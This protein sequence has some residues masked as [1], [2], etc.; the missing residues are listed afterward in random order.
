VLDGGIGGIIAVPISLRR[1][2]FVGMMCLFDVRALTIAGD[3]LERLIHLGQLQSDPP[4]R[5]PSVASV[6]RSATPFDRGDKAP[7]S[8]APV[9]GSPVVRPAARDGGATI[10]CDVVP[11]HRAQR[12]SSLVRFHLDARHSDDDASAALNA[13]K[14]VIRGSDVM[15]QWDPQQ[16]L[17]VLPDAGVVE[18]QKV[19]DR[20]RS[21]MRPGAAVAVPIESW[22]QTG[23]RRARTGLRPLVK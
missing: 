22:K 3:G 14:R 2:G 8:A 13:L 17:V 12:P 15:V 1:S 16:W 7:S 11:I 5:R 9:T 4:S 23:D 20:V 18:A 10:R 19:V 21:A 6:A